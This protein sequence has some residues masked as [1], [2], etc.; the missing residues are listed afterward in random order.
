MIIRFS[1][2]IS[3]AKTIN[4]YFHL[5]SYKSGIQNFNQSSAGNESIGGSRSTRESIG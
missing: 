4:F 1:D 3:S 5:F 2:Y